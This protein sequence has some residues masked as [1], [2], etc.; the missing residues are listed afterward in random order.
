MKLSIIGSGSNGNGYILQNEKEALILECGMPFHHAVRLLDGCINKV[1][2]CLVTHSHGDHAR[3][4][5]QYAKP[6]RVYATH[7]TFIEVGVAIDN[8][9]YLGIENQ[10][11]FVIGGFTILPFSTVH[12]TS[13]PCGFL[14]KHREMGVCLFATD[15][16]HLNYKF[17]ELKLNHIFIEC[18]HSEEVVKNNMISG[19]LPYKVGTRALNTHMC[20]RLCLDWFRACDL[21]KLCNVVLLHIS[22][23]NGDKDLFISEV[24]KVAGVPVYVAKAGLEIELLNNDDGVSQ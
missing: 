1:V 24:S 5:R 3:Y 2:G 4:V 23:N 8:F 17:T 14:V 16:H 12:D 19:V 22:K 9:H 6:F 18:N 7:G 20:L 11:P 15:T 10:K 13:E 21:S